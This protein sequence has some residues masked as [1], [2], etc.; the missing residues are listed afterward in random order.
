MKLFFS[1]PELAF[2]PVALH[3][4]RPLFSEDSHM[5]YVEEM[6]IPL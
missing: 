2:L 3:V 6:A 1:K 5:I 4:K